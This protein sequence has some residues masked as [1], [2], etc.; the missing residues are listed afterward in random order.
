MEADLVLVVEMVTV[1]ATA[2]LGGYL[3]NRL[4][5]PVLLGYLLGGILVG[6][7][8]GWIRA[9]ND[10][11]GL[12]EVGVALLLFALGVEF[13]IKD[14]VQMRRIALGGGSLQILLTI[15][16]GGGLVYW[17]GLVDSAPQAIFLG[18]ALSLFN[19]SGA[20]ELN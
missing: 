7:I 13:S 3:M 16:L 1:L 11:A 19:S 18:A 14:L 5:Q 10:I 8:L 20:E 9:E 6:P 4:G 12:A 17:S 15:L 2:T